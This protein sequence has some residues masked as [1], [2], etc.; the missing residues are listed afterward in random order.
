MKDVTQGH[1][2]AR[3][4]QLKR[5]PTTQFVKNVKVYVNVSSAGCTRVFARLY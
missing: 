4:Q 3:S 5:L 2:V 1:N